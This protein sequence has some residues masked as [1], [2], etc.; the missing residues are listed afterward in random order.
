MTEETKIQKALN[1]IEKRPGIRSEELAAALGTEKKQ[2]HATMGTAIENRFLVTSTIQRPG[3]PD[4]TEWRLSAAVVASGWEKWKSEHRSAASKPLKAPAP[5]LREPEAKA[6]PLV[7][8]LQR[9]RQA[10]QDALQL[11]KKRIAELEQLSARLQIDVDRQES[12]LAI[13]NRQAV[14]DRQ[15]ITRLRNVINAPRL[16]SEPTP[17]QIDSTQPAGFVV[18]RPKRALRRFGKIETAKAA[19]L[20]AARADGRADVF[21]LHLAGKA[22]QGAE[23]KEA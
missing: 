7:Q 8:N 3:K 11:A 14:N 5:I 13:F 1:I 9:Q 12:E 16:A 22:V 19:A 2:L 4:T 15:E 17:V 21:A 23:W 10:D 6:D 20:S 18:S